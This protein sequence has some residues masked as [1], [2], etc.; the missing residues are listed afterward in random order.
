MSLRSCSPFT[1]EQ[2]WSPALASHQE[3]GLSL[4]GRRARSLLGLA[5]AGRVHLSS[6][7]DVR[8]RVVETWR[9]GC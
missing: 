1:R 2:E 8:L 3:M 9:W 4:S 5:C 7:D 6:L